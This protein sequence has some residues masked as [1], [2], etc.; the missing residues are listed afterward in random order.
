MITQAE[1]K[2]IVH[3]DAETGI[4]TCTKRRGWGSGIVEPGTIIGTIRKD[5]YL[6]FTLKAIVY[7]AH[8]VAFLY[9][10]GYWPEYDVDHINGIKTDNRW[11]NL[12]HVSRSCNNQNA[13]APKNSKSGITGVN[14]RKDRQKWYSRIWVNGKK[15]SLGFYDTKLDAALARLT[16]EIECPQWDCNE[17]SYI[18]IAIKKLWPDFKIPEV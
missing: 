8:R 14:F 7:L 18:V 5:G 4:F 1:L 17:R 11:C 12:R 3:Y 16:F 10:E 13:K 2:E 9:M 15:Y 6:C